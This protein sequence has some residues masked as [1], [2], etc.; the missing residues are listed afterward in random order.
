MSFYTLNARFEINTPML[1]GGANQNQAELSVKAIKSAIMFWWR[2]ANHGVCKGN[3]AELHRQERELFG[4]TSAISSIRMSLQCDTK[5]DSN[6]LCKQ[7]N[8]DY[9]LGQDMDAREAL[10]PNQPFSL[11]LLSKKKIDTSVINA[12]KL[13]GLLG[14]L[15]AK[16]LKGFGSIQLIE[17][18]STANQDQPQ[19]I[20]IGDDYISQLSNFINISPAKPA[21]V[22][23]SQIPCIE[24]CRLDITE[25]EQS[26]EAVMQKYSI[27]LHQYRTNSK[28][29][30][31]NFKEDCDWFMRREHVDDNYHPERA[32]F[33]LPHNYFVNIPGGANLKAEVKPASF[34]RR[35]SPLQFHVHKLEDNQWVGVLLYFKSVFLPST[36]NKIDMVHSITNGPKRL[37]VSTVDMIGAEHQHSIISDFMSGKPRPQGDKNQPRLLNTQTLFED[38]QRLVK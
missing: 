24:H 37:K 17:L 23:I 10:K 12:V 21:S 32:V 31:N 28:P 6:T 29:S 27:A 20:D 9:L 26:A 22:N 16:A 3:L 30:Y 15:G 33:G 2:V 4:S 14:G 18:T 19:T 34:T 25:P 1:I 36:Q 38:G 7:I 5:L 8:A 35:Q 13:F 11:R